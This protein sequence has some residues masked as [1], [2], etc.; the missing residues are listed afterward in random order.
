MT[1][2]Y[3]PI[4][5]KEFE[6]LV[7][8]ANIILLN[9]NSL[10]FFG[11]LSMSMDKV[12]MNMKELQAYTRAVVGVTGLAYTDGKRIVFG[13]TDQFNRSNIIA[14]IVHEIIHI[15]SNHIERSVGKIPMIW[16]LAID[17]V[18]NREVRQ[19]RYMQLPDNHFFLED[20]HSKDSGI[21]AEELYDMMINQ[22]E[23]KCG[24]ESCKGE[25]GNEVDLGNGNKAKEEE[26]TDQDGNKY[27]VIKITD[28][29]GKSQIIANDS[30]AI[31]GKSESGED[32]DNDDGDSGDGKSPYEILKDLASQAKALWNSD[33][34]SK[35]DMT[36][37]IV[38]LLNDLFEIKLPWDE[39][40]RNALVY[41]SA[42][43]EEPDWTI[44]NPYINITY[45]PSYI[46]GDD[47]RSLIIVID[48]SASISDDDLK[49]FLGI[50]CDSANHF[51]SLYFIIHDHK[52]KDEF[53][54][55]D[56]PSPNDVF[57]KVRRFTGRGGTSHDPPFSRIEDLAEEIE[58]SSV[59]FLTDYESDV[60]SIYHNYDWTEEYPMTWVITERSMFRGQD[61]TLG[62]CDT[63]TIHITKSMEK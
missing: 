58:I 13:A 18:T 31:D 19:M 50:S 59:L 32:D 6:K 30:K 28:K 35:G 48:C 22:A 5:L 34:I 33:M 23:C 51:R 60:E 4:P 38:L 41:Q 56:D 36:A 11:I 8:E 42:S 26:I 44:R 55:F 54:L 17:H 37:N 57:D 16:A 29:N 21:S 12:V 46:D 52:V 61:V 45:L 47:V 9:K 43:N 63:K 1:T 7:S 53:E 62:D 2:E 49:R 10:K 27:K 3:K 25:C 40:L 14:I 24:D 39:I 15:I 20:V